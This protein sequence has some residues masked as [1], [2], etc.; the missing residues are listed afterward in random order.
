MSNFYSFSFFFFKKQCKDTTFWAKNTIFA[1][2]LL[3]FAHFL[4]VTVGDAQGEPLKLNMNK[5]H[6]KEEKMA[7]FSRLLD[8]QDRLRLQCPW[9]RKQTFESLRPNT[10]EET[11]ELCDALM[12]RD[13]KD[14]KKELGDV[15]EHVMFY[16]IIGRE[17]GEFDICDVCNQ[18]ADKLMFRHPFINWNEEGEWSVSNPDMYINENGQVVYKEEKCESGDSLD[19]ASDDDQNSLVKAGSVKPKTSTAVE[20]TWEQIKQQEKDGNERVLSG[21]PNALPS[22]IKAYRIQD[23]ARNVGFDWKNK[24]DVWDKVQEELDELKIELAKEDK[25][26]STQ[27]LGDFLFSVINAARLYK[28]NPDN[29]LEHT[30]QKFIRRFN[31]VEDHTLKRGKNLKDISLEEMD[32]LWNEAKSLEKCEGNL[33]EANKG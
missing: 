23:K 13:Y 18:E 5:M 4:N 6:T 21:V 16:S 25:E 9:D 2:N 11:F 17:D 1:S 22:L 8:V 31:Y 14:I 26:K 24:E 33:K 32:Q 27:E 30:N 20:K 3:I 29:A 15:L 10:V 12:K 19:S 28:L 7:A